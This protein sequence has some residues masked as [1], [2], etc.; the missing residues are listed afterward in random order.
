M[1]QRVVGITGYAGA[2]KDTAAS[3]L[4]ALGWKRIAVA[5]A[6]KRLAA[7]L[8]WSGRKDDAPD[9]RPL[10]VALGDGVRRECGEGAWL[11]ALAATV[12]AAPG[13]DFVV[14]DVRYPN[15]A[16]WLAQRGGLLLRVDRPGVEPMRQY[17]SELAIAELR[18]NAVIVNASTREDLARAT[19]RAVERLGGVL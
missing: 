11:A 7:E 13:T 1:T 5:D 9:G 3:A 10:L 4:V 8:G 17:R 2:G 12:D 15:E 16:A 19:V 18:P 14:P 6:V